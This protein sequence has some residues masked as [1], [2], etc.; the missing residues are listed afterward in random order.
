MYL[1]VLFLAFV[2]FL[3]NSVWTRSIISV[4]SNKQN[5]SLLDLVF[6]NDELLIEYID[7]FSPV[8]KSDYLIITFNI[9]CVVNQTNNSTTN[10]CL[11]EVAICLWIW[12]F[13][14]WIGIKSLK[15]NVLKRNGAF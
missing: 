11:I 1:G 4:F 9:V 8:D 12:I 14:Q 2:I 10:I 6:A 7:Q 3:K 15:Q 5:P 13:P